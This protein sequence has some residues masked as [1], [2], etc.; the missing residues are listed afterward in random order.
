MKIRSLLLEHLIKW[1]ISNYKFDFVIKVFW[2]EYRKFYT[3][4][5]YNSAIG[6]VI[7]VIEGAQEEL[8]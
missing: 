7:E 3:E 6:S 1:F 4:D 5:N 8:K 2:K